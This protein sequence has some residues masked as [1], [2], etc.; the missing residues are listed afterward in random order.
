[1]P[2]LYINPQIWLRRRGRRGVRGAIAHRAVAPGCWGSR[3]ACDA[4]GAVRAVDSDVVGCAHAEGAKTWGWYL[5]N[6]T[7]TRSHGVES[8]ALC[9]CVPARGAV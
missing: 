8:K 6:L 2:G 1:M 3:R 9:V 4:R 7:H 5:S